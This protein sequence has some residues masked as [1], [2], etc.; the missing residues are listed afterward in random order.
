M[1]SRYLYVNKFL[2]Q[3]PPLNNHICPICSIKFRSLRM[4]QEHV[5]T[6][7]ELQQ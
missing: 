6:C 7:I 4:L 2:L 3:S 1:A 5:D